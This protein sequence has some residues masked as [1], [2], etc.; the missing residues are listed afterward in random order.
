M[1]WLFAIYKNILTIKKTKENSMSNIHLTMGSSQI[2]CTLRQKGNCMIQAQS[3]GGMD[4]LIWQNFIWK[5]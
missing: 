5:S 2:F 3:F 1:S 4:Y